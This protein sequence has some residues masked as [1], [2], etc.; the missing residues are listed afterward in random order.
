MDSVKTS[1]APIIVMPHLPQVGRS[2]GYAGISIIG[3]SPRGGDFVLRPYSIKLECDTELY[4]RALI[5]LVSCHTVLLLRCPPCVFDWGTLLNFVG[6]LKVKIPPGVSPLLI[7][8]YKT[9]PNP[10]LGEVGHDKL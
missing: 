8:M 6:G 1:Y 4:A 10:D 9:P 7:T 2:R 3:A 5:I